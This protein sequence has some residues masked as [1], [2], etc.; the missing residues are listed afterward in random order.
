VEKGATGFDVIE[1]RGGTSSV[2]FDYRV[3][4]KRKGFEQMRL[5]YCEAAE[6]DPYLYPEMREAQKR[7][8]EERKRRME[9]TARLARESGEATAS[10]VRER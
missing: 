9:E 6:S 8:F 4:A 10:A 1:L 2:P 7:E 5:E 3:V